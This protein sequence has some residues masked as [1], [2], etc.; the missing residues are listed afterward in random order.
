MKFE[1]TE[2]MNFENAFRGMRNPMNSWNKSDSFYNYPDNPLFNNECP[3]G[4]YIIGPNDMILA[5]RLIVAGSTHRK[6]LRQIFI[7]VDITASLFWWK[8]FDTYKIG[9]VSNSCST[10][11][12]LASTPITKECF[13]MDDFEDIEIEL[14]GTQYSLSDSWNTDILE[15][16]FLRNK[17]NETKEKKYWKELIRKLPDSWLQ[18]RTITMNYEN[19][20]SMYWQR[21][22]HKLSE[23]EKTFIEWVES[24]PYFKE[25]FIPES[26]KEEFRPKTLADADRYLFGE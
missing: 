19:A 5:K 22:N 8:E 23:W 16:E 25:F 6:F 4:E 3:F 10:M 15:L 21:K 13:E 20:Y 26:K 9:T 7:S 2:V 24:L 11:H 17:Y 12:K 18:K 1:N 14:H